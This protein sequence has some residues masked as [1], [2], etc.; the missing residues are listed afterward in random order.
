M[1]IEEAKRLVGNQDTTSLRNMKKA[2][3]LPISR[4]MNTAEDWQRLEAVKVILKSRRV[5]A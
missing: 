5:S 1:T 3:E 4:F 2:L